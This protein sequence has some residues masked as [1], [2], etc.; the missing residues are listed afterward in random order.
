MQQATSLWVA[1]FFVDTFQYLI[2]YCLLF[3]WIFLISI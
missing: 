1:C 2:V 3:M